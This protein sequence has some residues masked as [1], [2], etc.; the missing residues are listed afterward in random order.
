MQH[1]T[2]R[3]NLRFAGALE[4]ELEGTC[5]APAASPD[6]PSLPLPGELGGSSSSYHRYPHVDTSFPGLQ[7]IHQ[8]PSILLVNEFLSARECAALTKLAR[9]RPRLE[10]PDRGSDTRS[11]MPVT[12]VEADRFG[13]TRKLLRLLRCVRRGGLE[14]AA[15]L[16]SFCALSAML[17][18]C[19]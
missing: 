10:G 14:P 12:Q 19:G 4:E 15:G 16:C 6:H 18:A 5:D 2:A 1:L 13:V 3:W 11:V 8:Q 17:L 9:R 7:L